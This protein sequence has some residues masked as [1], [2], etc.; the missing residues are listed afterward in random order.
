MLCEDIPVIQV[1]WVL[2]LVS[3]R[4]VLVTFLGRCPL[5]SWFYFQVDV[6]SITEQ[7]RILIVESWEL[8][9]DRVSEV[10]L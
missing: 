5:K 7:E 10:N 3:C 8:I 6:P 9:Q 1:F 2:Y 4:I